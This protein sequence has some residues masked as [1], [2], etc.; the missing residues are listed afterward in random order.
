MLID[1]CVALN[2]PESRGAIM[3]VFSAKGRGEAFIMNAHG[4]KTSWKVLL[5]IAKR[6]MNR[7]LKKL[8]KESYR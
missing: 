4:R 5:P 6:A 3:L 8:E 2:K 7:A 1:F